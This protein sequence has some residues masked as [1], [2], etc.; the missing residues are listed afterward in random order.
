LNFHTPSNTVI[1][2]KTT[3][4]PIVNTTWD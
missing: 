4:L 1:L 2:V 3:W